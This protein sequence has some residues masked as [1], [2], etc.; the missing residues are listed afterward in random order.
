MSFVS[1]DE[2]SFEGL[3]HGLFFFPFKGYEKNPFFFKG[4][5]SDKGHNPQ[6]KREGIRSCPPF[7]FF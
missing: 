6:K 1:F 4:K 5:I 3:P 2:G 7:R